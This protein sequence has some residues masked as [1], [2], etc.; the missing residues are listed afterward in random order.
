MQSEIHGLG[1]D[2]GNL[3]NW[4][5]VNFDYSTVTVLDSFVNFENK[6]QW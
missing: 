6:V 3:I 1:L 2:P 5:T 4:A